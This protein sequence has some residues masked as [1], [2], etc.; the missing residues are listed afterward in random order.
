MSVAGNKLPFLG[1]LQ[2]KPENCVDSDGDAVNDRI[3]NADEDDDNLSS[4][5]IDSA[6]EYAIYG[7]RDGRPGNEEAMEPVKQGV[8]MRSKSLPQP[9]QFHYY[10]PSSKLL[11]LS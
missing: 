3:G 8:K 7:I 11:L 5:S 6:Q 10:L 2:R 4:C 9:K 1:D